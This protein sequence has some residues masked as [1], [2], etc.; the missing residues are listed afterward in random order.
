MQL[1]VPGR[2]RSQFDAHTDAAGNT[3]AKDGNDPQ[4]QDA[5]IQPT[6]P[7]PN[8]EYPLHDV[9]IPG[10]R[11]ERAE[12]SSRDSRPPAEPKG[13]Q[14]STDALEER[15]HKVEVKPLGMK[16]QVRYTEGRALGFRVDRLD[17]VDESGAWV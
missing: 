17:C 3:L 8:A 13:E 1:S 10:K 2:R 15:L 16:R 11:L 14:F 9:R 6:F 4:G 5:P 7:P 12:S